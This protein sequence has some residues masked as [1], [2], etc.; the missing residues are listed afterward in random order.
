MKFLVFVLVST[1]QV[2]KRVY[3]S[4]NILN[5]PG[6]SLKLDT[7]NEIETCVPNTRWILSQ[8]P[9]SLYLS[10]SLSFAFF[11]FSS[12]LLFLLRVIPKEVST[13][14]AVLSTKYASKKEKKRKER[15]KKKNKEK[16]K[17]NL[18]KVNDKY[19]RIFWIFHLSL[20]IFF[21]NHGLSLYHVRSRSNLEDEID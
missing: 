17:G 11:L 20:H 2:Y 21:L 4:R 1:L 18:R 5:L 12:S 3:V 13:N 9:P 14:G 8:Q 16:D 10:L 15:K 6:T 19:T 7:K